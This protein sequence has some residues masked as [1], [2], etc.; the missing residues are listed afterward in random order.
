MIR[1]VRPDHTWFTFSQLLRNMSKKG[2]IIQVLYIVGTQAHRSYLTRLTS[3]YGWWVTNR[4]HDLYLCLH[5]KAT[6]LD[7]SKNRQGIQSFLQTVLFSY[8]TTIW[9]IYLKITTN[10][11]RNSRVKREAHIPYVKYLKVTYQANKLLNKIC[12]TLCSWQI[13][14][15]NYKIERY[16]QRFSFYMTESWQ[17][18]EDELIY[19]LLF[20]PGVS[21]ISQ[22]LLD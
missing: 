1:K 4:D 15:Y 6:V 11:S 8:M 19:L 13:H 18:T 12:S 9:P 17:N 21:C 2:T 7:N 20:M 3:P 16:V 14:L 22:Q 10:T 5:S